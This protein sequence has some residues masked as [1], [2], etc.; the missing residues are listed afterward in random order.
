MQMPQMRLI[1]SG[2]NHLS[3]ATD[4]SSQRLAQILHASFGVLDDAVYQSLH[5][6][7]TMETLYEQVHRRSDKNTGYRTLTLPICRHCNKAGE[8]PDG[9]AKRWR[10]SDDVEFRPSRQRAK[11]EHG[12]GASPP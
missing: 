12:T 9:R 3:R 2:D 4:I 7:H 6:T 11:G 10:A 5:R 1:D 8:D